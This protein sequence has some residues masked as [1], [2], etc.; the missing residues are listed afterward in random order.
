MIVGNEY[1]VEPISK[2]IVST[3][4]DVRI[5]IS[6]KPDVLSIKYKVWLSCLLIMVVHVK[7][8]NCYHDQ[9]DL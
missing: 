6:D 3:A 9:N 8:Y 4:I 5:A 1:S 7:L 2:A